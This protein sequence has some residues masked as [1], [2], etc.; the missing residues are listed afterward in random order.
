M[1]SENMGRLL[2][3]DDEQELVAALAESL[4][5][6]GFE[7]TSHTSPTR[8][9]DSLKE[10][11]F[12]LLLS[13]LM[14]PEMNGIALIEASLEIDPDVT[15]I[16]MTGQGTIQTAVEALKIGAFDY[17][18]KPFKL[19]E[20][21]PVLDRALK[22][23]RATTDNRQLREAL[24][25]HELSQAIAFSLDQEAILDEAARGA[26]KLFKA[27]G[28]SV[29]LTWPDGRGLHVALAHGQRREEIVG[30]NVPTDQGI[31][32]WVACHREPVI[33]EGAVEDKRFAPLY[34]RE[35]IGSAISMPMLV[36]GRVVGVLNINTSRQRRPFTS[37][38]TRSLSVLANTAAAALEH[39]RLNVQREQ[40]EE[41]LRQSNHRLREVLDELK[42]TQSQV[43]QQERL[44]ALGEM[45][46]GIAHDF[47][48][49]LTPILGF[50]EIL[51]MRSECLE[52]KEELREHLKTINTAAEDAASI[53]SRLRDF[54]RTREEADVLGPLNLNR[55]VKQAIQ[56]TTPKWKD[57]ALADGISIK[58]KTDLGEVPAVEGDEPELR[59]AL[60]N[61]I[62]NAA[63][64]I[65]GSGT[66]DLRTR[67]DGEAHAVLEVSDSGCGMTEVVRKHCVDPFFTT[68]GE[69][70]TGLG[71]G[72]VY[73]IVQR[74]RGSIDVSSEP[75]KGT[76]FTLRLPLCSRGGGESQPD[77]SPEPVP[78]LR[79][80]VVDDE[81][82]VR[83]VLTELLSADGHDVQTAANGKDGLSR[84]RDGGFDL[85]LTD[86]AMPEMNGDQL[87]EAIKQQDP[88]QPVVMVS[89]F[90]QRV[91]ATGLRQPC[92]DA[93]VSK[94]VTLSELRAAIAKAAALRPSA[95]TS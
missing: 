74:H 93:I 26:A 58:M 41:A 21:I 59:E 92:V 12:D 91:K 18:S 68:K 28:V 17:L 84:F 4:S 86:R 49:V 9:L 42:V 51:L 46:S 69:K 15:C 8:A 47:N 7:V 77:S 55:I 10:T 16:I 87:A 82:Q 37:S 38:Q 48:N 67:V 11:E 94:P 89:G 71:L 34:P 29:M 56:L 30:I 75:G 40:D 50:S 45:A 66:I 80:L 43:I 83:K 79:I 31:A 72:I 95:Y 36:G 64:A 27:D 44:R 70:G 33:L 3:V 19:K 39:A 78:N 5:A 63:D 22:M 35:D 61:L 20:L 76:T 13:D 81:A 90:G 65:S 14:M 62:F 53:V 1:A 24:A 23:A 88:D 25:I 73:G 60:T 2:V 32:G 85:V 6:Q 52:D 57:Q 54:Y